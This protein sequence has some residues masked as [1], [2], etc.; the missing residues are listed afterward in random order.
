MIRY[1]RTI[2]LLLMKRKGLL[3]I[4][5]VLVALAIAYLVGPTMPKPDYNYDLP[6]EISSTESVA[7]L[8]RSYDEAAGTIKPENE[9]KLIWLNERVRHKTPYCMLYLHGFS[10]SPMEAFPVHENFARQFRMNA[11]IPRLAEHGLVSDD[12]LL[13]MTPEALWE[14]AKEALVMAKALGDKIV[15]MAT[16]TGATLALKLAAEYP[17]SIAGLI[18]YSPNIKIYSKVA[19]LLSK[20]WGLQ[21]ARL[22]FGGKYR[23]F[24]ENPHTDPYWYNKYRAEAPVYLQ[25][26]VESTMKKELFEKVKIPVFVGYY[27]K[28]KANQDKA[29]SVKAI[30][31]MFEN[32]GTP[33]EQK[34]ALAFPDAGVHSIPS[35]FTSLS[36]EEVQ[37][38]S[39]RFA[40]EIM[41]LKK[42]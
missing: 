42:Y 27:Y 29:V 36:W 32:L 37:D 4:P 33:E 38:S 12:E 24:E 6:S 5:G 1:Y 15:V 16:S 20:P 9:S 34:K 35:I 40:E 11:L 25:Q 3:I 17:E 31:W 18:L 19:T 2:Y 14:S 7:H 41:L 39:I 21:I 23:V 30:H 26:L 10:A 8:L 22:S 28:D 13:N